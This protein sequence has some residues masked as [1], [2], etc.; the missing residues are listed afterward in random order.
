MIFKCYFSPSHKGVLIAHCG[1]SFSFSDAWGCQPS[2]Q[3]PICHLH[4]LLGETSIPFF[5]PFSNWIIC[6]IFLFSFESVFFNILETSSLLDLWFVNS[7][8]QSVNTSFPH[9]NKV[10]H[11][12]NSFKFDGS[13]L[14]FL[15][16][17]G[18]NF[19]VSRIGTPPSP[20]AWIFSPIFT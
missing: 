7:F 11:R 12:A 17:C 20:T 10:S 19:L 3:V 13:D 6:L 9:H 16:M 18:S 5:C 15:C 4:V 14:S 2:F 1:P 8:F